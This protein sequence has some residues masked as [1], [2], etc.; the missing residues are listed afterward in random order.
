MKL[1]ISVLLI[2]IQM[3]AFAAYSQTTD[4]TYQGRLYDNSLPPTALYDFEF[5]LFDLQVGGTQQG[6]TL[7]AAAVQVTNGIFTL[8]LNFGNQFTGS[9]RFL[10]IAVRPA[11]PGAYTQ[12]V[13]RQSITS[14]PYAIRSLNSASADTA[15]TATNATNATN[16]T[17]ATNALNL[18]GIA[19]SQYVVT[20]DP[21]LSDTRNPTANSGFY[22]QNQNGGPQASSNFYLSGT[23]SAFIFDADNHY[24]I[25]G[26]RVLSVDGTSNVFVGVQA[27][28]NNG[29]GVANTFVGTA[30]GQANTSGGTNSFFGASAGAA[31]NV[32]GGN[33]YF[34]TSA[35]A[36]NQTGSGNSF[37]GTSA[38]S[39]NTAFSNSFFG[40]N[41]G[42]ANT[43]GHSNSFFGAYAGDSTI[44]GTS[45]AFFG[46][47]AG[48][49][50]TSGGN[51]S[52]FGAAAGPANSGGASNTFIGNLSG[53]GNTSGNRNTFIGDT[54][55]INSLTGSNNSSLGSNT[56][57]TSGNLTYSTV[58]GSDAVGVFSNQVML[59]RASLDTVRIGALSAATST[60]LCIN[61]SLILSAC[62]SSR[63]YKQ[64]IRPF[65]SGLDLVRRL[66][67]VTYDWI[68][69][70]EH[71]LGLIAEEVA[72]I[73][74]LLVTH[75]QKGEIQGVKYDQI[76]VALINAVKEQQAQIEKQQQIIESQQ[77]QLIEMKKLICSTNK[78]TE[79]CKE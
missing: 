12:L 58:I 43:G 59:G 46:A 62:S 67:P 75:N 51:N 13:P 10:N 55:G 26:S 45:N 33:S 63:I 56:S 47:A 42:A 21:R 38:G 18:G 39:A 24:R 68:E 22:I 19:A 8:P 70:K 41:A 6:P 79:F 73:E 72:D 74:P 7:Q 36:A 4:F 5:R 37:F 15:T 76:S 54:S 20:T 2:M 78:L 27:G 1:R 29:S 44:G 66:R 9:P 57:Y 16:A 52:F 71:D 40:I 32:G 28:Q 30:A 34:G 49:V 61:P 3:T 17:T 50:N 25:L 77:Q 31:N 35:G 14:T 69:S 23:G 65:S 11:G 53:L 48:D 64:N 60:Q